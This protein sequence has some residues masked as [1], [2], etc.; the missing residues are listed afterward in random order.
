MKIAIFENEY[1]AAVKTPF[2]AVNIIYF[3]NQLEVTNFVSSQDIGDFSKIFDF[4][5]VFVDIHLSRR[6]ELD[7]FDI[8][9]KI[10]ELGY[11]KEQIVV[12]TGHL[13]I[14]KKI[15]EKGLPNLK[16]VT[17][18]IFLDKLRNAIKV[19]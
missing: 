6:S 5:L 15:A 14:E 4:K 2:E 18:P 9:K 1:E 17:K 10:I 8:A 3:N 12:L 11:P 13:G 19:N 16:V 7:G